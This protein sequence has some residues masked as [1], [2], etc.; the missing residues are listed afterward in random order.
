MQETST[1]KVWPS[2]HGKRHKSKRSRRDDASPKTATVCW[3]AIWPITAWST[4]WIKKTHLLRTKETPSKA[5]KR[6]LFHHKYISELLV[7]LKVG[8][9]NAVPGFKVD[10]N[11]QEETNTLTRDKKHQ[12]SFANKQTTNET[13]ERVTANEENKILF[14]ICRSRE[15]FQL[16]SAVRCRRER[17]PKSSLWRQYSQLYNYTKPTRWTRHRSHEYIKTLQLPTEIKPSPW[18]RS[19]SSHQSRALQ[20]SSFEDLQKLGEKIKE[21]L[22]RNIK[23]I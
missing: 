8:N 7:N 4:A 16:R 12:I 23:K 5:C 13:Q 11:V 9:R 3:A 18:N 22:E 1:I 2:Y 14:N 6:L 10:P 15:S 17:K 20:P 21:L 19:Q